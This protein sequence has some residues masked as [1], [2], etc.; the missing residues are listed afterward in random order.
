M[1][2]AILVNDLCVRGGTHKQ[3]LRLC[4]YL[5]KQ[6]IEFGVFTK[7]YDISKTYPDFKKYK[8]EYVSYKIPSLG[9]NT[10]IVNSV[11]NLLKSYFDER[12]LYKKIRKEYDVVNIH[13]NGF[14]NI[15]RWL[16]RRKNVK[17]F[18]QI[19]DLPSCFRIGANQNTVDNFPFKIMR[20]LFRKNVKNVDKITVNVTKNKERVKKYLN[21]D[22]DVLYCGVDKNQGLELHHFNSKESFNLL[23]TGVFF[24]YRNYETLISVVEKLTKKGIKIHLDIIGDT[25]FDEQYYQ[26]ICTLVEEKHLGN[27]VTIHGQVDENKYCELYNQADGFAFVN[28]DQSWGLAVFEAMSCGL[29]VIV[30]NSVG[31]VELL[32]NEKDCIILD[33][34]DTNAICDEIIR[35]MNDSVYYNDL[36]KNAHNAVEKMTWDNMYC[37][38]LVNLFLNQK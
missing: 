12:H 30:S 15:I 27:I 26:S 13:D 14:F 1:K 34:F 20:L 33:P 22:A 25:K 10:N 2:V 19:N 35:L 18:W 31:A 37:S 23:S 11:V 29:P 9:G 7:Y 6:D 21:C 4:E 32:N 3:V 38:K 8:I 28:V 16:K 24:A 36:S 5:E 17:I